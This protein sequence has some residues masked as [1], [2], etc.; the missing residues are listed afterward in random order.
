MLERNHLNINDIDAVFV[1][2]NGNEKNDSVY[3]ANSEI[4]F[5]N[6]P[7]VRYKHI[8]GEHFTMSGMG[9]YTAANCLKQQKI[10]QHLL[11]S[12]DKSVKEIKRVLFYNHS[13]DKEHGVV[14]LRAL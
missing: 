14:L 12:N 10:P 9:I 5:P 7:L 13:E 1:G 2:I 4:L 3:F 11:L 8:F 6:L